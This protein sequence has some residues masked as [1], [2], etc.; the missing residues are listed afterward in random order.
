MKQ[1]EYDRLRNAKA[2]PAY[3]ALMKYYPL[4]L[5]NLD[6][7][8]WLSIPDYDKYAVSN[9]GRIKSLRGRW[10]E[11]RILKP[12]LVRG[13]LHVA[14]CS[15][16][17]PKHFNVHRLVAQAFI[18]NPQNKPQVN[19]R[20]GNKL[21][22]HVSNLEWTTSAQNQRHAVDIGLK[23]SGEGC[24][25]SK[26]TQEQVLYIRENPEGLTA[27]ALASLLDIDQV[28][29]SAIQR[30]MIWKSA[31]GVIRQSKIKR[32]SAEVK[33]QIRAEYQKGVLGYGS[34][35]LA[36]KYGISQTTISR[37]VKERSY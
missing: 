1:K 21:N 16:G 22:N 26:L 25:W 6:G 23:K 32:I 14:L 20:D 17:E 9:F 36:K 10:G 19:H 30:G 4:T 3:A 29:I 12:S 18:P 35:A 2:R 5:D 24:S 27:I 34:T 31:G 8:Q 28:T 15:G 13:Y 11:S 7:E 37:I 33:A